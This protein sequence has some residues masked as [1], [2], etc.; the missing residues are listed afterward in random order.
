M[1]EPRSSHQRAI[2]ALMNIQY[3]IRQPGTG[4]HLV[5]KKPHYLYP[6]PSRRKQIKGLEAFENR[7][8]IPRGTSLGS[9][10]VEFPCCQD[11]WRKKDCVFPLLVH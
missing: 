1:A 6:A 9:G 4:K 3:L 10:L 5:A 7:F 2:T 11:G 8:G